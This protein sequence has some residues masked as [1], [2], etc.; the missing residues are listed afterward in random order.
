MPGTAPTPAAAATS[1]SG[2]TAPKR[3]FR[4]RIIVATA[5]PLDAEQ[6]RLA[7]NVV[8]AAVGLDEA[9]GDELSFQVGL[10]PTSDA[11][12]AA[13][14]GA[15][16]IASVPPT[17][18]R[19][20]P[21]S[22]GGVW[23]YLMIGVALFLLLVVVQAARLGARTPRLSADEREAMIER[24]RSALRDPEAANAG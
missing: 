15:I 21:A 8:A 2:A 1:A 10:G 22:F 12:P 7:R 13:R 18:M 23:L 5:M 6:T 9:A 14:T 3:D 16:P 17:G 19:D 20:G 24:I 11:T 4:L